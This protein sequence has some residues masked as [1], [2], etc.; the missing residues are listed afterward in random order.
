MDTPNPHVVDPRDEGRHAS[1]SDELWGESYYA[2]F[3]T[4]DGRLGGYIRLGTYPN[5]G[6]TWWT[7]M[8]VGVDR[9]LVGW[10]NYNLPALGADDLRLADEGSD[11]LCDPSE[12]LGNFRV[13][14]RGTAEVHGAADAIYRGIRGAPVDVD[15]DLTWQT[16]G[17]PYHYVL[18]TRYE[19]PCRVVGQLRVGNEDLA[20]VGQ[21]QR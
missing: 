5:L 9:P 13:V 1:T 11:I 2:D 7:A 15:L 20:I 10:T 12:P 21:G 14:A 6:V 19:I 16:D 17:L 18:T 8:V 4:L 3:V